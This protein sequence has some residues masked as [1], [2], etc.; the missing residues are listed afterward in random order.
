MQV[1]K[2]N[3]TF[4]G[5]SSPVFDKMFSGKMIEGA[6][7]GTDQPIIIPD[8]SPSSFKDLLMWETSLLF[9]IIIFFTVK[10]IL[11]LCDRYM[12]SDSLNLQSMDQA[13]SLWQAAQKYILPHLVA[14]CIQYVKGKLSPEFT[15]RVLEFIKLFEDET[16]KVSCTI[17]FQ[18]YL[19]K[20]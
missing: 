11:I 14:K 4:L 17:I 1:I 5:M 16:V 3:K 18:L 20:Y 15:I 2:A 12:Y 19:L 7:G 9:I 10:I 6:A 13:L 8:L